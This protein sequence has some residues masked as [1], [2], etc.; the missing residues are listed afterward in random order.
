M[1]IYA[2]QATITHE[3]H[4]CTT[5]QQLPVFYLDYMSEEYAQRIALDIL[6]GWNDNDD[7]TIHIAL[8][9]MEAQQ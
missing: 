5:S 3:R 2:V 4:G 6:S 9:R 1:T 8:T 7:T